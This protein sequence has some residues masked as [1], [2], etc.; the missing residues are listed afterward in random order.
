[1]KTQPV[2]PAKLQLDVASDDGYSETKS[3]VNLYKTK[4][5][6]GS[7]V[8]QARNTAISV[9]EMT[10][11]QFAPKDSIFHFSF[12]AY[13]LPKSEKAKLPI[14]NTTCFMN[15]GGKARKSIISEIADNKK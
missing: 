3:Q 13:K 5:Y 9:K 6:G 12:D 7:T 4:F 15:N 14:K 11:D 8:K 1:M 10:T 2:S